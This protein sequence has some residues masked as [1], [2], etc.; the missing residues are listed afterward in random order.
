MSNFQY[1][2]E[3]NKYAGRTYNDLNQYPIFPWVVSNYEDFDA[4]KEEHY[5]KLELPIGAIN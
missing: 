2:M 3:I 4:N 1:L 5:R